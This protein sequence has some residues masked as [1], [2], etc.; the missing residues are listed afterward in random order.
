MRR[1]IGT[2]LIG[3]S[4]LAS[5]TSLGARG[6]RGLARLLGA[7]EATV[8]PA[9]LAGD[10]ASGRA[11]S[12]GSSTSRTE[13]RDP[14]GS[15]SGTRAPPPASR[16]A[17]HLGQKL[18]GHAASLGKRRGGASSALA[19][20]SSSARGTKPTSAAGMTT[21][22]AVAIGTARAAE[23]VSARTGTAARAAPCER[24]SPELARLNLPGLSPS[25][26]MERND[27]FRAAGRGGGRRGRPRQ[28]P[29]GSS[30]SLGKTDLKRGSGL[31]AGQPGAF[32]HAIRKQCLTGHSDARQERTVAGAGA[33]KP[34]A[35]RA[36]NDRKR[37][38]G[39]TAL[40]APGRAEA[41]ARCGAWKTSTEISAGMAIAGGAVKVARVGA[42]A[43]SAAA[44]TA[45]ANP[46]EEGRR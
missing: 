33:S 45:A 5:R 14:R 46:T 22:R 31:G 16:G 15:A 27:G 6:P 25:S 39:R 1:R 23:A 4:C 21:A 26:S 43:T 28:L 35:S 41:A 44:K 9:A 37:P 38:V 10:S 7:R 3:S 20:L 30:T 19:E 17:L 12:V 29:S 36:G 42:W 34:V 2:G 8:A 32:Q 18:G 40:M 24:A 11:G 13:K